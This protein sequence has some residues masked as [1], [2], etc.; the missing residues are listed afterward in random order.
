MKYGLHSLRV[1]GYNGAKHGKHG[2]VLAV[3]HGGWSSNAHERY[4]RFD[5]NDVLDLANVIVQQ[6]A[7]ESVC[8]AVPAM[9]RVPLPA[10]EGSSA[11]PLGP[12]PEPAS[13]GTGS[14]RGSKRRRQEPTTHARDGRHARAAHARDLNPEARISVYWTGDRRWF[15]ATVVERI[16]NTTFRIIY[17]PHDG[18]Q[19]LAERTFTH[20]L[21][22]ERWK[23]L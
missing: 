13:S 3:A 9:Q 6:A 14:R 16:D 19:S 22:V 10:A 1:T 23:S 2:T 7:D 15:R 18:F 21:D 4:A 8:A 5:T 17:D 20:D 12:R 11:L